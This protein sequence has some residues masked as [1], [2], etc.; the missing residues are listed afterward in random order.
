MDRCGGKVK[1]HKKSTPKKKSAGKKKAGP[2]NK[3]KTHKKVAKK[4]HKS[5]KGEGLTV[6]ELRK[7]IKRLNKAAKLSRGGVPLKKSSLLR[8]YH[9]QKK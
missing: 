1:K 5:G 8:L 7:K 6:P 2:H 4:I 3:R 9:A